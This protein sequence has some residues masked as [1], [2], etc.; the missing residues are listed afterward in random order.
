MRNVRRPKV[1]AAEGTQSNQVFTVIFVVPVF[2]VFLLA[3]G[4]CVN[5]MAIRS[6]CSPG[7]SFLV[8]LALARL[9]ILLGLV[10]TGMALAQARIFTNW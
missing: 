8:P 3:C 6:H 4:A 1:R 7:R 2:G 5:R 9:L 10:A